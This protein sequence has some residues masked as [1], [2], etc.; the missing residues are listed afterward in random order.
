MYYCQIE[1]NTHVN[2]RAGSAV[3]GTFA[4]TEDL[5]SDPTTIC[6]SHS[7]ASDTLF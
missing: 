4:L 6:V 2:R 1:K 7:K 5:G 3:K